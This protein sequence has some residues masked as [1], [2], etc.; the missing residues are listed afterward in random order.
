M[1]LK[2]NK[3][4]A[5]IPFIFNVTCAPNFDTENPTLY[6]ACEVYEE[7]GLLRNK[8]INFLPLRFHL[9]EKCIKLSK[10][11]WREKGEERVWRRTFG[12]VA[13]Y[14]IERNN[15]SEL[16]SCQSLT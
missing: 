16:W 14:L 6:L 7:R 12:A 11:G 13:L 8:E 1:R 2:K 10:I 4:E 9:S 15:L 3:L 5:Q